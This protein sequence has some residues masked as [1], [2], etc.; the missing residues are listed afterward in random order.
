MSKLNLAHQMSFNGPL[1]SDLRERIQTLREKNSSLTL[2]NLGYE[3]KISGPFLSTLL[4]DPNPAS[5]R[6][7]HIERIVSA[8][9][10]LESQEGLSSHD[11][12]MMGASEQTGTVECTLEE[13]V[14]MANLMGFAVTFTPLA[15]ERDVG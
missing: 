6:T 4:R 12:E 10:K 5:V 8:V 2:A 7:K 3:M 11:G 13:L 14:R 15:A 9:K 1:A